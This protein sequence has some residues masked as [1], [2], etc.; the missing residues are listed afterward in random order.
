[1]KKL[2][3]K[4]LSEHERLL[5]LESNVRVLKNMVN[6]LLEKQNVKEFSIGVSK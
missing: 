6:T 2:K 4:P 3:F 1:L 5:N